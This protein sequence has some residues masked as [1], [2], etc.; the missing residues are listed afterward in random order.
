M[1]SADSLDA[2]SRSAGAAL[3]PRSGF[4][5]A[6]APALRAA[7]AAFA[8]ASALAALGC[9]GSPTAPQRDE[10]FYLHG[11]GVLD[12]A[13]SWELYFPPL[14]V[15]PTPRTP[16]VVGVGVLDGDVRF[17]RPA[18]WYIRTADYT[19]E[20]RFISY[21]SPRRFLFS[22]YERFD[23]PEEPWTELLDRFEGEIA[24]NG[25]EVLGARMPVASANAQGRAYL[26]K[27]KVPAKP[28]YE[29]YSHEILLRSD[30]RTLL[31]QI[32]H[33]PEIESIADEMTGAFKSILVY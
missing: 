24:Q 4:L 33:G 3:R 2:P 20:R 7:T 29:S 16:R 8:V 11:G 17:G 26:L 5:R 15:D 22:I 32:V 19:P 9:G 14:N 10:V 13:Y 23:P 21:Q 28:E 18:D 12:R 1:R 6:G 31:V 30:K 25:A 27:T